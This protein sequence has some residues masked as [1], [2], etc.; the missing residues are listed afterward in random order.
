MIERTFDIITECGKAAEDVPEN[1][2]M[3]FVNA[4]MDKEKVTS[5]A[6]IDHTD[7]QD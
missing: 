1:M 7:R 6:L 4:I 3:T 2:V 5:V